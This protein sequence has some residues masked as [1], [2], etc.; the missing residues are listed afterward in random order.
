MHTDKTVGDSLKIRVDISICF[1]PL[2]SSFR[3]LFIFS[4]LLYLKFPESEYINRKHFDG[5]CRRMRAELRVT[6]TKRIFS[7]VRVDISVLFLGFLRTP[8]KTCLRVST[9]PFR[10]LNGVA[11]LS[12]EAE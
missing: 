1:N 8:T 7:Q 9:C 5:K 3:G 11:D 4:V 6:Y 12:A 2:Y 10:N